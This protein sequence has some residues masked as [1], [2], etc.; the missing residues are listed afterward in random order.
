[1]PYRIGVDVGTI[2]TKLV[3]LDERTGQ[4]FNYDIPTTLE[5]PEKGFMECLHK[6][7]AESKV[8]PHRIK[9]I[10][11]TTSIPAD[12]SREQLRLREL[13][14]DERTD[15]PLYFMKSDGN[16]ILGQAPN[17][18]PARAN[19]SVSISGLLAASFIA[20]QLAERNVISLEMGGT[21]T[22]IGIV[23]NGEIQSGPTITELPVGGGS[24]I[25]LD[26]S[27]RLHVGP[28]SE[29]TL[30]GPASYENEVLPTV[31]DA[32]L[33]LERL[34]PVS[35]LGGT[36]PL[37][38]EK[39]RHA[40][41]PTARRLKVDITMAAERVVRLIDTLIG[42]L[43]RDLASNR[44]FNASKFLLVGH[45]GC[46]PMHASSVGRELG[47]KKIL[48]PPAAGFT[49]A[50]GL[51]VTDLNHESLQ[52]YKKS[53]NEADLDALDMDFRQMERQ[54]RA[55]I[56]EA[57]LEEEDIIQLRFLSMRHLGNSQELEISLAN[58]GIRPEAVVRSLG[59]WKEKN[60]NETEALD[61][62]SDVEIVNL[63]VKSIGILPRPSLLK[64]PR[65]DSE[66][67]LP[68]KEKRDVIL[69]GGP[70]RGCPVYNRSSLG[71]GSGI[72]GPAV[73][74]DFDSTTILQLNDQC[75]VDEH[76]NLVINIT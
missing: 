68:V 39:A 12:H 4:L 29:A 24:I 38:L 8:H 51:L 1:M 30:P 53:L 26:E 69:L 32:Y 59:T 52:P 19:E 45:G 35:L 61:S 49:S 56:S 44:E 10:I 22:K 33:V 34:N 37:D 50:F 17:L 65:E 23:C 76:L 28:Q 73:V 62:A 27:K 67:S 64:R 58:D 16:I 9:S 72:E 13:L 60:K 46:G 71:P 21:T 15:A 14:R 54:A 18:T 70:M 47:V 25:W 2:F 31:T 41:E 6:F 7:M 57:G 5:I 36:L 48:I 3:A 40:L 42:R 66:L 75:R 74:E 20:E 43:L 63:K 55:L 11:Y